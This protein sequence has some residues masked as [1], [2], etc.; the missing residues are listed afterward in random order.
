MTSRFEERKT[1][2][3]EFLGMGSKEDGG[4]GPKHFNN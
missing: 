4:E 3:K 2:L 1:S